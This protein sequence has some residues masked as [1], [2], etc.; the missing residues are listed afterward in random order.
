MQ[1]AG[2]DEENWARGLC[3]EQ[4]WRWRAHLL[5][6]S[7]LSGSEAELELEHLQTDDAHASLQPGQS[8]ESCDDT[9]TLPAS[10]SASA[11][12]PRLP[13]ALWDSGVC[14]GSAAC[15]GLGSLW[16][17][18]D[19]ILHVGSASS[20]S[21]VRASLGLR[22]DHQSA[23]NTS[24]AS[25]GGAADCDTCPSSYHGELELVLASGRVLRCCHVPIEE[26]KR[27]QP[28]K[29]WWQRVVLPT[30][31]VFARKELVET[32]YECLCMSG[33]SR[34]Y[35]WYSL[36]CIACRS[37]GIDMRLHASQLVTHR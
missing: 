1:G 11:S 12:P 9:R 16:E 20:F 30:C 35:R 24:S 22:E 7:A 33:V 32:R 27:A 8:F 6:R 17:H 23:T 14:V 25:D 10:V 19:A 2:D 29:D 34:S 13:T 31:L 18:V 4:W 5:E 15:I 36:R 37:R 26:G 21:T 28:S 3:P